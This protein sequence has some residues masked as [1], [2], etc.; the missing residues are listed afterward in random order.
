MAVSFQS[1]AAVSDVHQSHQSGAEHLEFEHEHEGDAN[2]TP[3]KELSSFDCHHCCHCH[4][5]S[6]H[7]LDN[8]QIGY[9][10]FFGTSGLIE[11]STLFT[12]RTSPPNFRPPIV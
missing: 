1:I 8:K 2:L 7:Y 5:V 3:Q 9:T 11:S 6:C 12:S 10:S 4:G